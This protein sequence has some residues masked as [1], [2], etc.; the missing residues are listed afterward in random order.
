MM[1]TT[2]TKRGVG[3]IEETKQEGD[4]SSHS[5]G[6]TQQGLQ[7]LTRVQGAG[8]ARQCGAGGSLEDFWWF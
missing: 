5:I 8:G 6:A 7:T 4:S 3:E 1:I 2:V